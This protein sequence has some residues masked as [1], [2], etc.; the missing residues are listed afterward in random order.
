M[1]LVGMGRLAAE[2]E[3]FGDRKPVPVKHNGETKWLYVLPEIYDRIIQTS[4]LYPNQKFEWIVSE[5]L[6]GK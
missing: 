3:A 4:R 2:F 6:Q 1:T 5:V